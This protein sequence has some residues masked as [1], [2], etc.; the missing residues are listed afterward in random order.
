MNEI[1]PALPDRSNLEYWNAKASSLFPDEWPSA[2]GRTAQALRR[3][4][5]VRA[6][7]KQLSDAYDPSRTD[8]QKIDYFVVWRVGGRAPEFQHESEVVAIAEAARLVKFRPDHC[9]VVL[10]ATWLVFA[11]DE[12]VGSIPAVAA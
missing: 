12:P 7:R 11:Q 3:Q 1:I 4:L 2:S 9:F 6:W 5:R 10:N 8:F